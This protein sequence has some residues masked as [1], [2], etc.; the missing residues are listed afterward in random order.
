[1]RRRILFP[2]RAPAPRLHGRCSSAE[3]DPSPPSARATPC[4]ASSAQAA[5]CPPQHRS[6]WTI[7][8]P[9][10]RQGSVPARRSWRSRAALVARWSAPSPRSVVVPRRAQR[11]RSRS[12]AGMAAERPPC[13][14][15]PPFSLSPAP[16]ERGA[17]LLGA[18]V[19]RRTPSRSR[20]PGSVRST[21][22]ARRPRDHVQRPR[23]GAV[24]TARAGAVGSRSGCPTSRHTPEGCGVVV[25][26]GLQALHWR[27]LS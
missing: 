21:G 25:T 13:F 3:S 2:S 18:P 10:R 12:V 7:T 4:P 5:Q 16:R 24:N 20:R 23:V 8:P 26:G 17:P 14:E 9:H 19:E 22:T 1:L 11:C 15:D 6:G 27:H